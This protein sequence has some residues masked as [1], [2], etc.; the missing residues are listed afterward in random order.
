VRLAVALVVAAVATVV[1][2][3][4]GDW[5]N[6]GQTGFDRNLTIARLTLFALVAAAVYWLPPLIARSR[7]AARWIFLAW[8]GYLAIWLVGLWP[9]IVMTDGADAVIKAREGIV[10]EWYSYLHA[11]LHLVV[12]DVVPH[13]AA[14]GVLQVV[15]LAAVLAYASSVLLERTGSWKAVALVNIVAACSAPILLNA[16]MYSRDTIYA[17]GHVF[18]ALYLARVLVLRR[19]ATVADVVAISLLTALLTRYRGDGVILALVVPA[20]ALAY[21]RPARQVAL[22]AGGVFAASLLLVWVVLPGALAVR[23]HAIPFVQ[24]FDV[25]EHPR[26][27]D[28]SLRLNPLGAVLKTDFHSDTKEQDLA[29]LN[30]VIDVDEA[31]TLSSPTE[32][33]VL[34]LGEWNPDATDE[35]YD[36]FFE[37]ADR[38]LRDNLPAV[39][40][41]RVATLGNSTGMTSPGGFTGTHLMYEDAKDREEHW[42]WPR[43]GLSAPTPILRLY[44]LQSDL[45]RGSG[46]YRGL[47]PSGSALHWNFLPWLLVLVAAAVPPRRARFE[48]VYATVV[49]SRVPLIVA[50]AP[51][52]QFKYYLAV[53][54]GGIVALGLLAPRVARATRRWLSGA[55][56]GAAS[57]PRARVARSSAPEAR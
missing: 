4:T 30:R 57:R 43:E 53:Q 19:S 15:L 23:D 52:A 16:V 26:A 11:L 6:P 50:A 2:W 22:R 46:E 48:F 14:V 37:V 10:Y 12:L 18:L 44:D 55:R 49:L 34:W 35:E 20:L 36:A 42:Y 1:A 24:S 13:V 45:L 25:R 31:R 41:N 8:V 39:A 17:A 32:V 51:A 38:L 21:L 3:Q 29:T 47:R 54:L 5:W 9:G 56:R 28:L 7:P 40:A 27:Y 33:P